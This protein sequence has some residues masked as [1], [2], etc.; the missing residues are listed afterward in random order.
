MVGRGHTNKTVGLLNVNSIHLNT[1][2]DG[3]SWSYQR[4]R[5]YRRGCLNI[6]SLH[7]TAPRFLWYDHDIPSKREFKCIEFTFNNPTFPCVGLLNVN[8][9]HLNTL[10][11]SRSWSYQGNVGLLNVNSIHLQ[12]HG[13]CG[14][15]TTYHQRRCLNV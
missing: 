10:F 15:T 6:Y 3:R 13:F 11:G 7:L 14:M 8:C 9:I 4:N 2:F 5:R 12:P 1:L